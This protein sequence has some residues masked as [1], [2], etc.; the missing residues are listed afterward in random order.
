MEKMNAIIDDRQHF[1]NQSLYYCT[2]QVRLTRSW[3]TMF[4]MFKM[5]EMCKTSCGCQHF[6]MGLGKLLNFYKP[7]LNLYIESGADKTFPPTT[8]V[9]TL[10]IIINIITIVCRRLSQFPLYLEILTRPGSIFRLCS[11]SG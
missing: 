11:F 6:L 5:I 9:S 10:I 4:I 3:L 2:S 8:N 1:A 7:L